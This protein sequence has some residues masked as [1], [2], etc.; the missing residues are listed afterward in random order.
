[1][2]GAL[3]FDCQQARARWHGLCD[4]CKARRK[5]Q[6]DYKARR[7]D[8]YSRLQA[9]HALTEKRR[10]NALNSRVKRGDSEGG[11]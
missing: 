9:E 6:A 3:C 8:L 2:G 7:I 1:M 5:S 11:S 10:I 4:E